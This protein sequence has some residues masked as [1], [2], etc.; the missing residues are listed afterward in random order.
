MKSQFC[1]MPKAIRLTTTMSGNNANP[2]IHRVLCPMNEC[3]G[4]FPVGDNE[5][6]VTCPDCET[7]L[8][9]PYFI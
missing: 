6:T 2:I 3:Q 9:N 1:T 8:R 4:E 7:E 5:E